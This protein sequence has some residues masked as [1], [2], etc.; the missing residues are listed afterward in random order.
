MEL[1]GKKVNFLG[2]S[3]TEGVGTSCEEGMFVNIIKKEAEL[4]EAR[5]YGVSAS[6][7]ARQKLNEG[8][9]PDPRDY[10]ERF[11]EM[12]DDADVVVVF[13][14]TNDYGHGN[15]DFGGDS[16]RSVNTYCGAVHYLMQGLIK[17]YPAAE[18]VFL[19]PIHRDGEFILNMHGRVLKDYVDEI[20]IA[21]EQYSIPVLDM[22]AMGGIYPQ[23]DCQKAALC[24]DGLHPNDAGNRKIAQRIMGFLRSL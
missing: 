21:A 9:G 12:D 19:T 2:D 5:N 14:G 16:D 3:I 22:Y 13:G 18:I 4:A 23:F 20:K 8:D 7:I 10:C 15:A 24:P 6:R 1:K 11:E 17:K